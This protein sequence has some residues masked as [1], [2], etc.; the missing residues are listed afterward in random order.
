MEAFALMK[1]KAVSVVIPAYNAARYIKQA[2]DSVLAQSYREYEIIVVDDG[3]TD[4]TP[5]IAQQFGDA[6]RC[7]R[8]SNRGL[9]AARN[10]GIKNARAE[11]IALL[12]SDDLWEPQFLERMVYHLNLHPEAAG[13]YCGF[14]YINSKGEVVGEPSLKI[15][16][17]ELFHATMSDDGNWLAPSAVMFRKRLAEHVGLFDESLQS[18]QDWDLWIR[19]SESAPFVGLKEALVEYRRHENNMSKDP[20]R[21][22]ND[23]YQLTKKRFGADESD[24][25]TWSSS[26]KK[27]FSDHYRG[28]AIRFFASG[29]MQKSI[30]YLQKLAEVSPEYACSLYLW[31]GFARAHIPD[32]YQFVRFPQQNW[33]SIG[34]SFV[35]FLGELAQKA[36][37]SLSLHKLYPAMKG[38]AFLALADEAGRAG[39]LGW[40][41]GWIR[42]AVFS[43]PRMLF[44][45]RFWGTIFRSFTAIRMRSSQTSL[46]KRASQ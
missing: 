29:R 19:L 13:I 16:P 1:P 34:A 44:E 5:V 25:S 43:S 3:S 41:C 37:H 31:R 22:I 6:I 8:Q 24:R 7:I 17:P 12:D 27:A 20:E 28:G 30:D 2:I 26:K 10:T 36:D 18:V 35:E 40:A 9:S 39:E 45:R 14:Q 38:V 11:I 42:M 46:P 33:A 15:V 23:I 21:M 4:E 32:E